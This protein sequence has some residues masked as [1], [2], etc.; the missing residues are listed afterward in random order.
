MQAVNAVIALG[1]NVAPK[2]EHLR[3]ALFYLDRLV[4]ISA[5]SNF[6]QTTA[7]D[8]V[9]EEPFM[10]A[11]C[12][13][14]TPLFPLQL[15]EIL[16]TVERFVGKKEKRKHH[17]R[18]IDLDLL[19]FSDQAY[20]F[21]TLMI[22]HPKWQERLFVLVPLLDIKSKI[23]VEKTTFDLKT[24]VRNFSNIHNEQVVLYEHSNR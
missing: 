6:Y 12:E 20:S 17:S 22:P 13:V 24:L 10:N 3:K 7:V 21:P 19:F 18:V 8:C 4:S 5:L 2:A 15:L 23:R 1:S 9:S 16:Q 11:V 14:T